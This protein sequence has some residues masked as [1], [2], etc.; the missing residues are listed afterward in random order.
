MSD[1]YEIDGVKITPGA[2][3]WYTLEH[4]SLSEPKRA[5]GKEAAEAEAA[6]I[7]K[8]E[9]V[10]ADAHI[11][12]NPAEIV[13]PPPATATS[14]TIP[15]APEAA[16]VMSAEAIALMVAEAVAK[17]LDGVR[18]VTTNGAP[19][20]VTGR[21]PLETPR[22]YAGQMSKAQ[23]A[24]FK[25]AGFEVKT[26]VLEEN[27]S[28]PPTGLFVGHNGVGYMISPGVE[29]DVPD[30]LLEVLDNAKM[31]APMVDPK[32]QKILGYRDR[33]KYPY[34]LVVDKGD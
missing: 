22:E 5:H 4:S 31:S 14:A 9:V 3:G 28:I 7:A 33:S 8:G 19:E 18:T 26:I 23:K 6:K 34:R 30:F 21:V 20:D 17:A 1:S 11:D 29:V 10:D 2:G 13:A 24:M 12:P 25:R 32:S 15:A 27:E 16:P